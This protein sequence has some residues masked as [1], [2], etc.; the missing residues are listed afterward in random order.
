VWSRRLSGLRS[1]LNLVPKGPVAA[2]VGGSVDAHHRP[3]QSA[4]QVQRAGVSGNG[5]SATR[6]VRAISWPSEQVSGV[7]APPVGEQWPRPAALLPGPALTSTR[8][9]RAMS[10]GRRRRTAPRASAW[11]PSRAGIDEHS[12]A[13][14][15]RAEFRSAQASAAGPRAAGRDRRSSSPATA[16]ASSTSCSITCAP[17]VAT[18][19]VNSQRASPARAARPR[20]SAAGSPPSAPPPPTGL[21]LAGR[22]QRRIRRPAAFAAKP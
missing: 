8:K 16:E 14:L 3:A 10:P 13:A 12:W 19:S 2:G 15:R 20:R 6:R 18:R 17:R 21:P 1:T 7:A 5:T 22:A 4:G 11:R 9:P